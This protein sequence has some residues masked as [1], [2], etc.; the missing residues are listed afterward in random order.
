MI[1]K[2]LN[3]NATRQ[4]TAFGLLFYNKIL[5]L[6]IETRLQLSERY[7]KTLT[8]SWG[9]LSIVSGSGKKRDLCLSVFY[10]K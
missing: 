2:T 3:F 1:S 10:E 4:Q 8:C 9:S 7:S 6:S 5:F